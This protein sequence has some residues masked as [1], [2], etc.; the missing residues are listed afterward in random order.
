MSAEGSLRSHHEF[1]SNDAI[2]ES[3]KEVLSHVTTLDVSALECHLGFRLQD[4]GQRILEQHRKGEVGWAALANLIQA[5]Q[6]SG[7]AAMLEA[8]VHQCAASKF[9][10]YLVTRRG[11]N[12]EYTDLM[13][14]GQGMQDDPSTLCHCPTI[15][16]TQERFRIFQ[17]ET[18]SIV[19]SL[20]ASR[21]ASDPVFLGS[22][23]CGRM[24]DLLTLRLPASFH[25]IGFD[26]DME[27][28]DG[29]KA[30]ASELGVAADCVTCVK[31][32]ALVEP[33]ATDGPKL[34]VLNSNGL[35]IYLSDD[36]C[37]IFFRSCADLV[38]PG[39]YFV[40]SQLTPPSEWTMSNVHPLEQQLQAVLFGG[41]IRPLWQNHNRSV[42]QVLQQV[43]KAG[44]VEV[45]VI[46]SKSNMFPTFVM[47]RA[48]I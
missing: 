30:F 7:E 12:W 23:P 5:T 31:R 11:L 29:V 45:K 13:F 35:N 3:L 22:F 37:D 1:Q 17:R 38:K 46:A 8:L 16:A 9:G 43:A 44:F 27:A 4:F 41:I 18:Q 34:D 39:G 48:A 47:R 20:I 26:K 28:L 19:D 32:D 15:Q 21:G 2:Q 14:S 10:H 6:S 24:R 25:L 40:V 36:E 42:E 33:I